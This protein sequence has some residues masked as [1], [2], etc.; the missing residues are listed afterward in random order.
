MLLFVIISWISENNILRWLI[1]FGWRGV[2]GF[3]NRLRNSKKKKKW[4]L[5]LFHSKWR[6]IHA[7]KNVKRLIRNQCFNSL[8]AYFCWTSP[9]LPRYAHFFNFVFYVCIL[10]T[11]GSV[12]GWGTMLQARR[13]RVRVPMRWIF[14][15]LPNPSSRTMALGS[16]QPVML[17][18]HIA[19]HSPRDLES[20]CVDSVLALVRRMF[21]IRAECDRRCVW[22]RFF[23]SASKNARVPTR[24]NTSDPTTHREPLSHLWVSNP[25]SSRVVKLQVNYSWC[26][27]GAMN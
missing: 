12:V 2:I 23:C 7:Y 22:C 20:G 21:G 24:G 8:L 19:E 26:R 16:T 15:C 9:I 17:P 18:P 5:A 25:N 6:I 4:R 3:I 11:R 13:S 14:F 27:I 10:Y 1:L